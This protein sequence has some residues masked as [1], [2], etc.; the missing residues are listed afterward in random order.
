MGIV[1]VHH[2]HNSDYNTAYST[3]RPAPPPSWP[4]TSSS[5]HAFNRWAVPLEIWHTWNEVPYLFVVLLVSAFKLPSSTLSSFRPPQ[6]I[7]LHSSRYSSAFSRAILS[8]NHPQTQTQTQTPLLSVSLV[9]IVN[10]RHNLCVTNATWFYFITQALCSHHLCCRYLAAMTNM[11][12][13]DRDRHRER[14]TDIDTDTGS[15]LSSPHTRRHRHRHRHTPTL[16][17]HA[18]SYTPAL[19]RLLLEALCCLHLAA[20]TNINRSVSEFMSLTKLSRPN[21]GCP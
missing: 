4:P 16:T 14:Y 8:T 20:I 10:F 17:A 21:L 12:R 19:T 15:L 9:F 13:R 1:R 18:Y 6:Y 3:E 7:Y 2:L 5:S 11:N